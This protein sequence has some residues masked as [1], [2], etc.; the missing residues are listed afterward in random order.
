MTET[1]KKHV[2]IGDRIKIITGNQKGI[3]GNISSINT[4]KELLTIDTVLPR[5]KFVKNREGGESKKME[6]QIPIHISNVMLWDKEANLSS[7]IGYKLINNE[8]SVILKNQEIF[9][10]KENKLR[11]GYFKK[12]IFRGD[13]S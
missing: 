7:K 1:K 11:N 10:K 3:I 13:Y 6:L 12:N 8:K 5:I 2:K 9:Y 4:K